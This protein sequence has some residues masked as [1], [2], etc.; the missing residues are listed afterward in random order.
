MASRQFAAIRQS[1]KDELLNAYLDA[2]SLNDEL[3][4][5]KDIRSLYSEAL[6]KRALSARGFHKFIR[7]ARTIADLADSPVI[8]RYHV[9][10]ALSYRRFF[11]VVQI[12]ASG[13]ATYLSIALLANLPP[14]PKKERPC[15]AR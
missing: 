11:C 3:K 6:E 9:L 1:G 8:T 5:N 15:F 14:L 10:V 13:V 2:K 12:M 7:V 4:D